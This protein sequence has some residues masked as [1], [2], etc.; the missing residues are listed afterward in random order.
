MI[1]CPDCLGESGWVRSC[2]T[3]RGAGAIATPPIYQAELDRIAGYR[4]NADSMLCAIFGKD[5]PP[6]DP[7]EVVEWDRACIVAMEIDTQAEVHKS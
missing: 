6:E 4:A 1:R 5:E 3:C 7:R 2:E